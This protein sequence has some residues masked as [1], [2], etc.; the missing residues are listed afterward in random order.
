M[1]YIGPGV[2]IKEVKLPSPLNIVGGLKTVGIAGS[3]PTNYLIS[4]QEVVKGAA[5]GTDIVTGCESGDVVSVVGVGSLPGLYDYTLTTDYL[6]ADNTI[7][8]SP[9]GS[10]PTTGVTYYVTFKKLK[11]STYYEATAFTDI[12]D[13]RAIHGAEL[14]DGIVSEISLAA[15]LAF[16]N[17]ASQVICVQQES[18]AQSDE[19]AAIDKLQTEEID[20][21]C[22]PGM[23]SSGIQSYI[24][25]HVNQMSSETMK[26]ERIWFTSGVTNTDAIAT[27]EAQAQAFASERVVL[28]APPRVEVTLHDETTDADATVTVPGGYSGCAL[29]GLM[30]NPSID[31]AEPITR[32][33]LAA[34]SIPSDIKYKETE[35]NDMASKG[36]CVLVN[37]AGITRVRHGVTT[38]TADVNRIELSV[39]NIKD[40]TKKEL[41]TA[42]YPYIGIK[43][44]PKKVLALLNAAIKSY[45]D[46]KVNGEIYSEYRNIKVTQS[47]TDPRIANIHF[48]FRPIQTLT[49]I[50]ITFGIFSA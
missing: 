32:K 24:Y 30:A 42:L 16:S 43:F 19:Q 38:S 18:A 25:A 26:K 21:L 34:I 12:D 49:W 13:V 14:D 35:M 29:A 15:N 39:S 46:Q 37:E 33:Q 11:S 36:I 17:G 5:G 7:D 8:W 10:E 45:C 1:S 22:T 44:A 31:E 4:N 41:R 9:G 2:K 23:T 6:V 28:F 27:L 40:T 48:E 50:D 20:Y 3:S 47:D